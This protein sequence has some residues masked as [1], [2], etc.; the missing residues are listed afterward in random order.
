M[1]SKTELLSLLRLYTSNQTL[2]QIY[3]ALYEKLPGEEAEGKREHL[4]FRIAMR[5]RIRLDLM[6]FI[7]ENFLQKKETLLER[8]SA[9][10]FPVL[11][12]METTI[13]N[14]L[15]INTWERCHEQEVKNLQK[16][17]NTLF[18]PELDKS[19]SDLLF[20]HKNCIEDYLHACV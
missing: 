17:Y 19:L 10:T 1:F 2:L 5:E 7:D 16:Y 3:Y 12:E 4:S 9:F 11:T 13:P 14:I 15:F 20:K 6:H 18:S 8:A